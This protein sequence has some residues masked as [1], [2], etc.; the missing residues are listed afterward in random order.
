VRKGKIR[1]ILVIGTVIGAVLLTAH[2][3]A[4]AVNLALQRSDYPHGTHIVVLPT[5]NAEADLY[6]HPV[7]RST[8]EQLHRIDGSGWLQAGLWSFATGKGQQIRHHS[9]IFAYAI[10]VFHNSAQAE[11]ALDDIKLGPL[12][13]YHVG[14]Q[15]G[16]AFRR[17]TAAR[18]VM[19]VF[20]RCGATEV[21]SYYEYGGTAPAAIAKQLRHSF[22]TQGSHL[23]HTALALNAARNA[24]PPTKTPRPTRTPVPTNTATPTLTLTPTVTPTATALPSATATDTPLPTATP[25]ATPTPTATIPPTPTGLVVTATMDQASYAPNDIATVTVQVTNDGVPVTGAE[26]AANFAYDNGNRLCEGSTLSDG[27]GSCSTTVADEPNGSVVVVTVAAKAPN[28]P[29]QATVTTS[30]TIAAH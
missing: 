28:D 2:P 18:S 3:S 15:T 10:N 27:S 6:F 30:F 25:T 9:V 22:D 21:E 8:F 13:R 24:P 20:V 5:T 12:H 1:A 7:H 26:F 29:D 19:F 11:H 17:V 23:V 16:R 14:H 4:A